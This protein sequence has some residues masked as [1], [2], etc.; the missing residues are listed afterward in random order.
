M[1]RCKVKHLK[2]RKCKN[3][4]P[5]V[6]LIWRPCIHLFWYKP[7]IQLFSTGFFCGRDRLGT[8]EAE[9]KCCFPSTT[10]LTVSKCH[11]N[12][13]FDATELERSLEELSEAQLTKVRV[14]VQRHWVCRK[15]VNSPISNL[16]QEALKSRCNPAGLPRRGSLILLPPSLPCNP[17]AGFLTQAGGQAGQC[18]QPTG[19]WKERAIR[20]RQP[21][22][23][24]ECIHILGHHLSNPGICGE[25]SGRLGW[26]CPQLQP[27]GG[28]EAAPGWA[29]PGSRRA[30]MGNTYPQGTVQVTPCRDP[31]TTSKWATAGRGD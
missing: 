21:E 3:K 11:T 30:S 2:F 24:Q 26:L 4:V 27:C 8:W 9:A 20:N 22:L 25:A 31:Q 28:R 13:S 15:Q 10:Q 6:M 14:F 17:T 7:D 1:I 29:L 19:P 16:S 5:C 23:F 12:A 18:P